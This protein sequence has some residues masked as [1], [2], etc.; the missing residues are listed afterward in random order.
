RF[1][2]QHRCL[3]VRGRDAVGDG[4]D[5]GQAVTQGGGSVGVARGAFG[6]ELAEHAADLPGDRG[7]CLHVVPDVFVL[8]A[9]DIGGAAGERLDGA[10]SAARERLADELVV[11]AAV[12]DD[13]VGV[14]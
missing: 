5:G 7:D 1:G 4:G 11:V 13:Q 8:L 3:R 10:G 2:L 9:V 14:A 12:V 6:I